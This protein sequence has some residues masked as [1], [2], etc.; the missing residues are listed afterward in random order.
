MHA[1]KVGLSAHED[2]DCDSYKSTLST[3]A[4][5]VGLSENPTLSERN[6][7]YMHNYGT[8]TN[9]GRILMVKLH[10]KV[11]LIISVALNKRA[12][13]QRKDYFNINSVML[14]KGAS[15]KKKTLKCTYGFGS[16][17]VFGN[18]VLL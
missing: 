9:G 1:D 12:W 14:G 3:S 13:R 10:Q 17:S 4:D 2:I 7:Y 18:F 6:P 5:N 8:F 15:K 16:F 11:T